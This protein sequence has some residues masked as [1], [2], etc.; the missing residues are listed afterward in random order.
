M[1]VKSIARK[2]KNKY[3]GLLLPFLFFFLFQ[4]NALTIE[5]KLTKQEVFSEIGIE[6]IRT[7]NFDSKDDVYHFIIDNLPEELKKWGNK[8]L[9]RTAIILLMHGLENENIHLKNPVQ[10]R[11]DRIKLVDESIKILENDLAVLESDEMKKNEI[12]ERRSIKAEIANLEKE[13]YKLER[14][15]FEREEEINS[16]VLHKEK[17]K[18]STYLFGTRKFLIVLLGGQKDLAFANMR[19]E[20]RDSVFKRSFISLDKRLISEGTYKVEGGKMETLPLFSETFVCRFVELNPVYIRPPCTIHLTIDAAGNNKRSFEFSVREKNIVQ[21][22]IGLAASH[23]KEIRIIDDTQGNPN[24]S[25]DYEIKG[26]LFFMLDFHFAR[27]IERFRPRFYKPWESF[28]KRFGVFAGLKLSVDPLEAVFLGISFALSKD[29]NVIGGVAFMDVVDSTETEAKLLW[30]LSFA[31]SLVTRLL[32]V[33][34]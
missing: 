3:R 24:E 18:W 25:Y 1:K 9:N 4:S 12:L 6:K 14:W 7:V 16:Y 15:F 33:E 17:N 13:R 22:K 21:F 11:D 23:L 28:V 26:N 20:G 32:G 19:A 31:P 2:G 30:G 29:I 5:V 34:L 10:T 27:D 8:D